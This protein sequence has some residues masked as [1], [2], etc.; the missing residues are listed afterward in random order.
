MQKYLNLYIHL[1]YKKH[2]FFNA[3]I[4]N[5]PLDSSFLFNYIPD[6]TLK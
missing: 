2:S 4:I 5:L 6:S 1:N 3:E